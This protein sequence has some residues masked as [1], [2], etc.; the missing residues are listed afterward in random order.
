MKLCC[1]TQEISHSADIKNA[2]IQVVSAERERW[3]GYNV[4]M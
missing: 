3:S 4:G 2:R 1:T